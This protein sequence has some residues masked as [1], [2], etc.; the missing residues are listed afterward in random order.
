MFIAV[1]LTIIAYQWSLLDRRLTDD[2]NVLAAINGLKESLTELQADMSEVKES[3]KGNFTELKGEFTEL[4][5]N[6]SERLDRD[7]ELF[8]APFE[9]QKMARMCALGVG[10]NWPAKQRR[11]RPGLWNTGQVERWKLLCPLAITVV[12]LLFSFAILVCWVVLK[13]V[14]T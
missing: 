13:R 1:V 3:F 7:E 5:G 11:Q 14:S 9:S 8:L 6:V 4:K 12:T 10:H 2:N